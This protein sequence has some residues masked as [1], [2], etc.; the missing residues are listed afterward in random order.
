MTL[1]R[2]LLST[3][4]MLSPA[5]AAAQTK[6]GGISYSWSLPRGELKGFVDNSSRVGVNFEGRS[7]KGAHF[8]LGMLLGWNEFYSRTAAPISFANGTVTGDQYRHVNI[9][10]LMVNGNLYLG[11]PGHTRPYIGV[12]A[13]AYYTA[14]LLDLGTS[15]FSSHNWQFGL[16]PEVGILIAARCNAY[17][18]VSGRYHRPLRAGDYLDGA[19]RTFQYI[20]IN[21]GVMYGP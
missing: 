17:A 3:L 21:V 10:P 19:P 12:Q 18:F 8:A 5:A 9:F 6:L 14:Q 15:Q 11:S 20:S 13:G 4:L 7:F 1:R 2:A 16:A